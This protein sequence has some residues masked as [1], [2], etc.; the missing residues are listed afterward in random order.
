MIETKHMARLF[1]EALDKHIAEGK[2][3]VASVYVSGM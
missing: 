2:A 3:F 1:A